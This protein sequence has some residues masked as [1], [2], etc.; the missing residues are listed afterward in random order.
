MKIRLLYLLGIIAGLLGPAL[1]HLQA[2][3]VPNADGIFSPKFGA[4]D[5]HPPGESLLPP[6]Y[7]LNSDQKLVLHF[8]EFG[9]EAGE[10]SYRIRHCNYD[11]TDSDLNFMQYINGFEAFDVLDYTFSANTTRPYTTYEVT[12]PSDMMQPTLAGNYVVEVFP[13]D[14]PDEVLIRRRF[15]VLDALVPVGAKIRHASMASIRM[16]HQEIYFTL[17]TSFLNIQNVFEDVRVVICQNRRWDNAKFDVKP[18]HIET[19]KLVYEFAT[20]ELSFP[21]GNQYRFV[22]LKSMVAVRD[23]VLSYENINGVYHARLRPDVFRNRLNYSDMPDING[24]FVYHN[25]ENMAQTVDPDYVNVNF[26]L[27]APGI[28]EDADVFLVGGFSYGQLLD[29]YKMRPDRN[30][31]MYYLS[32][33]MKQG[34]YN[35]MYVVRKRGESEGLTGPIEGDFAM[36]EN[37]YSVFVYLRQPGDLTHRLVGFTEINSNGNR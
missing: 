22:D 12:I 30:M 18:R 11:W 28:F 37:D 23:P 29:K 20:G 3:V 33:P 36:A 10:Y 17:N 24:R 27:K 31:N 2:S 34:Y 7:E 15:M 32:V 6:I 35:Y 14:N 8:D 13:R 9:Y 5:I 16:S 4:A 1:N 25:Q 26:V 19:G 21:G